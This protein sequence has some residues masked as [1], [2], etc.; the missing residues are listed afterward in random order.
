ME[1]VVA[2]GRSI[3]VG[4][5]GTDGRGGRDR[6]LGVG[7]GRRLWWGVEVV[8]VGAGMRISHGDREL[9]RSFFVCL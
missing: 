5:I 6:V 1:K 7:I 2:K 8:W 4:K 9:G 3:V